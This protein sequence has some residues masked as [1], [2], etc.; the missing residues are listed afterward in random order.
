[1]ERVKN[2]LKFNWDRTSLGSQSWRQQFV[3]AMYVNGSPEEQADAGALDW[4]LHVLSLPFKLFFALLPP[5]MIFDGW[6]CFFLALAVIGVLTAVV[7]D[8]ASMASC[9][10]GIPDSIAAITLVAIGTS[11]PD[12][13]A[14][15]S[16]SRQD[17]YADNA[18]G[19]VTGSN[20]VNVFLGLG[21]PWMAG[22]IYWHKVG[23]TEEW[24][25]R[26]GTHSQDVL[27]RYPNG[28]FVVMAG[29]LGFSVMVYCICAVTA[30]GILVWRRSA[31]GGELGGRSASK[32]LSALALGSLWVV[33]IGLSIWKT[34]ASGEH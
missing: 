13:F 8:V 22:A 12:T 25:R 11:L 1:M 5:P 23:A 34:M 24:K 20:S 2:V 16:A 15:M 26:I 21:L 4:F 14:S 30:V 28:A 3:E 19:N 7:G 18:I 27:A 17:P 10:I 33:Y 6:L 32:Q 31:C 9:L 29:D